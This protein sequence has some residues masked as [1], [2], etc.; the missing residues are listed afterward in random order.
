MMGFGSSFGSGASSSFSSSSSSFGNSSS[1]SQRT[2]RR[3]GRK[4]TVTTTTA[5]GV[6]TVET[7][8]V[9]K[10]GSVRREKTVN[11]NLVESTNGRDRLEGANG[12]QRVHSGG[13]DGC[14]DT[15]VPVNQ[16]RGGRRERVYPKVR[17]E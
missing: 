14:D 1:R 12:R 13:A 4:E 7:E 15:T 8:I 2:I 6:T 5:N 10:D 17:G 9:E 11:G 3:N 16:D